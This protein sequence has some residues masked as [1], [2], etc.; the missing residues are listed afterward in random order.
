VKH[1][2][3]VIVL[4]SVIAVI[5]ACI[6]IAALVGG[7]YLMGALFVLLAGTNVA[8]TVTMHRRRQAFIARFPGLVERTGS[9]TPGTV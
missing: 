9:A 5:L 6:G 2:R 4:R 1:A 3:T 8:L 7:R